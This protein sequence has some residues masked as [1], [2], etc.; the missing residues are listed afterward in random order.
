MKDSQFFAQVSL[1]IRVLP[2]IAEEQIFALKGG[3]AI[4]LF[5]WNMPRLSVDID[6]TY[7]PL[8]GRDETL[9]EIASAIKGLLLRTNLRPA[10]QRRS[11]VPS[12]QLCRS[13]ARKVNCNFP[14]ECVTIE[15]RNYD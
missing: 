11:L 14:R 6:L 15:D 3:T 1:L 12:E 10:I 5:I 7:L 4:N 13:F 2:F 8:K 9:S